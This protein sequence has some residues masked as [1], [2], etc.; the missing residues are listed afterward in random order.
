MMLDIYTYIV[1]LQT[2]FT[3]GLQSQPCSHWSQI[4]NTIIS[5]AGPV[6]IKGEPG[7]PGGVGMTGEKG[8]VGPPG[9]NG[10]VVCI[11]SYC[12]DYSNC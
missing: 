11:F 5:N 9:P 12:F 10:T 3:A 4:I 6:G 1:Y 2:K 7:P 8:E